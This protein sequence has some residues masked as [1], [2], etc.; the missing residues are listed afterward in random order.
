ME[1]LFTPPVNRTD[2][3]YD[4]ATG[5]ILVRSAMSQKSGINAHPAANQN[6]VFPQAV[7]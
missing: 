3:S 7:V 1:T 6:Q 5:G 4:L 2:L